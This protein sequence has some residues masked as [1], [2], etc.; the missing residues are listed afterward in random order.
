MKNPSS[1]RSHPETVT[2]VASCH[3]RLQDVGDRFVVT[4][5]VHTLEEDPPFAAISMEYVPGDTLARRKLAQPDRCFS[6]AQVRP[7]LAQPADALDYA[8]T[9]DRMV[10][11]DLKPLNL[12]LDAQGELKIA[13]FGIACSLRQT[14]TRLSAE[15]RV[16]ML[17]LA[18]ASPQQAMG[19]P[20]AVAD[21]I[22]ALGVTLYELLTGKPPFLEGDLLAQVREVVPLSMAQRRA[23]LG[24]CD[25]EEIPPEWEAA[26]AACLEKKRG[27]PTGLRRG[28]AGD[29]GPGQ[30]VKISVFAPGRPEIARANRDCR[31]T[32]RSPSGSWGWWDWADGISA[33][34]CPSSVPRQSRPGAPG[35]YD[36]KRNGSKRKRPTRWPVRGRT[37]SSATGFS[38]L[39]RSM[40]WWMD[41]PLNCG[42]PLRRR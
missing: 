30:T 41:R 18:Y 12:L 33:A 37:R 38:R 25:R 23:E 1:A 40:L 34:A 39:R 21:D 36:S 4:V 20:A 29:D 5:R 28:R 22:Y 17:T 42:N 19:K 11:R 35:R 7:W 2:A 26:V 10:H 27:R 3:R 15:A 16:A 9:R 32:P 14:V 24:V 8:H 13:D 6:P 31:S